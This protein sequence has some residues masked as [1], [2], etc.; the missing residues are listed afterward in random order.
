MP[1]SRQLNIPTEEP[2][3][4][5]SVS[6]V[7]HMLSG[8]RGT[9]TA[10]DWAQ[11]A[12][13]LLSDFA[14]RS[15]SLPR[16]RKD[17]LN[18]AIIESYRTSSSGLPSVTNLVAERPDQ[19]AVDVAI[20]NILPE[21]LSATLKAF[22]VESTPQGGQPFYE[23]SVHCKGRPE[24][25]LAV[26]ISATAKPNQV[27]VGR[28]V[29]ELLRR[30]S[31]EAVF[32]VGIA[33][34]R[35][36]RTAQGDVIIARRVFYYESGRATPVGIDPRPE[37]A[38]PDNEYGNGLYAYDPNDTDFY[39]KIGAFI[40]DVPK[41]KRPATLSTDFRPTVYGGPTI[42]ASG[43]LVLRDGRIL[44][45]M[46][47]RYDDRIRAVDQESYAFATSV[48]GIPWAIFRGISDVANADQDDRWKY[49]AA[50]FAAISLRD[51]LE[52]GFVPPDVA[53]F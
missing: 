3:S 8:F 15:E 28:P 7:Y 47:R 11:K 20:M 46:A 30:Y 48:R 33:G 42:I 12:V 22:G 14:R 51:F 52:N 36:G 18:D 13:L 16:E 23:A 38:E 27:H 50:G 40:E 9:V 19:K 5:A 43:E 32:L 29:A 35:E 1:S 39:S 26:V 24:R 34:G 10:S 41:A 4:E 21:E 45:G 44:E 49:T 2:D 37:N 53:T 31:P 6:L 25:D 17:L